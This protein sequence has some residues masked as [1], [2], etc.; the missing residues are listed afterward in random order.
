MSSVDISSDTIAIIGMGCRF[1]GADDPDAFWRLLNDGVDAI[2]ET[3]PDRW[4]LQKFYAAGDAQAGKTQSKWGGYVNDIDRFD[5]QLFGISPREASAMDPQQRLLLEV[6]WQAFEDAGQRVESLA[7]SKTAVYVGISSFDY[8]VAGL[9]YDDRAVIGPY[10]NTGGSSSIAANRI[11]YCFDLR[12]PSVAVDTACSSSLVALHMACESL[13]RGDADAAIAG[14]VNALLLPDFYVAFS[15][16]GVLSPD[17]RCKT[18]DKSANGYVRS[19]GAGVVMLK[20]YADAIRDGDDVVCV[21]RATAL[22]QDGRTDGMTV[23]SGDAQASLM[24]EAYRHAKV[25]PHLVGYV[26]AH[27]TGTPVGDP[28]EASA[29]ASVMGAKRPDDLPCLVGSVKTNIGH[30]EAGAG[31]ASVIKVALSLRH[32]TIPQHLHFEVPNPAIDWQRSG[33]KLPLQSTAWPAIEGRRIAGIN[34][35]GYGGANAHV[36]MESSETAESWARTESPAGRVEETPVDVGSLPFDS[37]IGWPLPI[38]SESE[39]ASGQV[40]QS[41]SKWLLDSQRDVGEPNSAGESFVICPRNV[42]AAAVSKRSQLRHRYVI[43]GRDVADWASQLDSFDPAQDPIQQVDSRELLFAC[44]GQGPQHWSM[45]RRLFAA[46]GAFAAELSRCDQEFLRHVDW[47]LLQEL[48]RDEESSRMQ[49]TSI[50]QPS[51]FAIQV[52]MARQWGQFGVTPTAVTG[53]S[54][55]EIAAAHLSGSLSFEDACLVAV[56][57]GRTMDLASSR[58]AM[59][60]AGISES[61]ARRQIAD[62]PSMLSLAAVNGPQSVTISGDAKAIETLAS[63]LEGQGLFCRRLAVEYAFHSP[64]MDPVESE[65]KRCLASIRPK[66]SDIPMISTVTGRVIEG[67]RLDADYWWRNVRQAVLFHPAMK[68][69]IELGHEAVVELGP[70]PVLSYAIHECFSASSRKARTVATMRRD[71][72]DV[73]SFRRAFERLHQWNVAIDWGQLTAGADGAAVKPPRYPMQRIS[74]WSESDSSHRTRLEPDFHPSL[75]SRCDTPSPAWRVRITKTTHAHLWDHRVR[76]AVMYPAAAAIESALAVAIRLSE[77]P[78]SD[79]RG[80]GRSA[81]G[82]RALQWHRP[83]VLSEERDHEIVTSWDA[84]RRRVEI[85]FREIGSDEWAKL[86]TMEVDESTP[87]ARERINLR[88]LRGRLDETVDAERCYRYCQS[89][90]L[91]YGPQFQGV[92]SGVRCEWESLLWVDLPEGL[93]NGTEGHSIHPALLD[94]CFHSMIVA[95]SNFDHELDDLYLPHRI[96][97]VIWQ[98]A[99]PDERTGTEHRSSRSEM[100]SI[101]SSRP[102]LHHVQVHARIRS[103]D[104]YR[105]LADLS[106]CDEDGNVLLAIEGFESRNAGGQRQSGDDELM[107]RYRWVH[108]DDASSTLSM[109]GHRRWLVFADETGMSRALVKRQRMMGVDVTVVRRGVRFLE[110]GKQTFQIRPDSRADWDELFRRVQPESLTD[111]VYA[112]ALDDGNADSDEGIEESLQRSTRAPLELAQ[113]WQ[114]RL[115]ES[116]KTDAAPRLCLVTAAT[117]VLDD[118]ADDVSFAQSPLIGFG[119]VLISEMAAFRTRLVDLPAQ[120]PEQQVRELVIELMTDDAEDEVMR[121]DERRYVRRFVTHSSLRLPESTVATTKDTGRRLRS[122]LMLGDTIGIADLRHQFTWE[123]SIGPDEVEIEVTA[124]GLNFS[125]VMKALGL[126][127]GLPDGPVPL[128]AECSGRVC[129]VGEHVTDFR[130]GDEV[131]AIARGSFATHVVVEQSLV[132]LKPRTLS[133]EQAAAVP[134][135]F[136]TADHALNQCAR[137]RRG[138]SVLIHSA[139][140]GVGLA[141][142]QMALSNGWEVFATAGSESKRQFVRN[143]GVREVMDSRSLDFADQVM[144]RTGGQGIDAVLNSLPGEAILR[145]MQ[146]LKTSGRFLEIGKRD[147]YGDQALDLAPFRNNLAFFAIDLDQLFTRCAELMG[148]RLRDLMR[149]FESKVWEPLPVQSFD[150]EETG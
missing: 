113:A 73:I 10:S 22:N 92:R 119:R 48:H 144:E 57:R 108:D 43:F 76:D 134:I 21:I 147:I 135:A 132:A 83:L 112:W 126:Y 51:L 40:A 131:V 105:M 18:F 71:E 128:G 29:I 118:S 79:A 42:L 85:Q 110:T 5:P 63:E 124:T 65:L 120:D 56:H 143:L 2:T 88:S 28:I 35:F 125:D 78:V 111:V 31:I 59:I 52:A 101:E 9:S 136:L 102:Q 146:I 34:G 75:G 99:S 38:S 20:R 53:H 84:I 55:G 114:R 66:E 103:K 25:E 141:A 121:R 137:L 8:A 4:N 122:K 97:R 77:S 39:S 107:Y 36:V 89:L 67:E 90:G 133:H 86:A 139:S 106:V 24:S 46:G 130:P 17:G 13:R 81:I 148:Q 47:S 64:Q 100:S 80:D 138:D 129:R 30:L 19:E 3:P 60:A 127:P 72:D 98:A 96:G 94:A 54:V 115:G 1:P 109:N 145:G 61:E 149:D 12:G 37:E 15:Q 140:G 68:T 117:Q 93:W 62:Q 50:A 116:R 87:V 44:C 16:L 27:G 7:G 70:H 45:G 74:L 150:A 69:A 32:Q 11:S 6:A 49:E 23:P 41:W 82:L 95:D 33:L 14:G 123:T 142:V 58:G 104:R 91:N 26:E